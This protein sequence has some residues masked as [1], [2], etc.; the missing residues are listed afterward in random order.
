M[1]M[2]GVR[3]EKQNKLLVATIVCFTLKNYFSQQIICG[4]KDICLNYTY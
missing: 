2:L 4:E 3:P 1:P